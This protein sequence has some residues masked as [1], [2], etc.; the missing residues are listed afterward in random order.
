ML[1]PSHC[2]LSVGSNTFFVPPCLSL[3]LGYGEEIFLLPPSHSNFFVLARRH[4]YPASP[5][6]STGCDAFSLLLLASKLHHIQR[7]SHNSSQARLPYQLPSFLLCT[8]S[9]V[10]CHAFQKTAAPCL[11]SYPL[12]Y[13][14]Y[15][16]KT[17]IS[18]HAPYNA[19]RFMTDNLFFATPLWPHLA[20]LHFALFTPKGCMLLFCQGRSS[21]ILPCLF[22]RC[23]SH[24]RIGFRFFG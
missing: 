24:L 8:S 11:T 19:S 22:G 5:N 9:C 4:S 20:L 17:T 15:H 16:T 23:P 12:L 18:R 6:P 7:P 13:S 1:P 2:C 21:S 3:F 14:L 10:A